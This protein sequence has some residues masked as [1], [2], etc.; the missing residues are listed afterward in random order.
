M[1]SVSREIIIAVVVGVAAWAIVMLSDSAGPDAEVTTVPVASQP[2]RDVPGGGSFAP[3]DVAGA[4][5]PIFR[6]EKALR[7]IAKGNLGSSFKL[8]WTFATDGPIKSSV[9]V[10][11]G[12]VFVASADSNV[13]ALNLLDGKRLWTFPT[14]G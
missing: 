4:H 5:W 2:V 14:G 7:G 9:A 13:Y 8:I 12:K 3:T 10:G 6:G 1:K 11:G